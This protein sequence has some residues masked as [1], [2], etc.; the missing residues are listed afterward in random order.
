[1]KAVIELAAIAPSNPTGIIYGGQGKQGEMK[2]EG[3]E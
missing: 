1:L 3:K 2:V